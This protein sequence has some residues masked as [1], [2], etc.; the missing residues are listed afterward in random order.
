MTIATF[1]S[2][3]TYA[4]PALLTVNQGSGAYSFVEA[5]VGTDGELTAKSGGRTGSM[6]RELNGCA[7]ISVSPNPGVWMYELGNSTGNRDYR[8]SLPC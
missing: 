3:I 8:F 1:G 7:T 6:A 5:E 2:C 4:F